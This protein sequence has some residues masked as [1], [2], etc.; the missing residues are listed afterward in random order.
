MK[1][2]LNLSIVMA[3]LFGG[4]LMVALGMLTDAVVLFA[5]G[6]SLAFFW[7]KR[8]LLPE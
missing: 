5:I 8:N 7:N 3:F 2:W 1:R 6:I 4:G